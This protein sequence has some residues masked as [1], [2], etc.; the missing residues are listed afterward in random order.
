MKVKAQVPAGDYARFSRSRTLTKNTHVNAIPHERLDHQLHTKETAYGNLRW[1]RS[2]IIYVFFSKM[3]KSTTQK[4]KKK[5]AKSK[6]ESKLGW[7]SSYQTCIVWS[8][9]LITLLLDYDILFHQRQNKRSEPI[10][11]KSQ[12]TWVKVGDRGLELLSK[13]PGVNTENSCGWGISKTPLNHAR[14]PGPDT[15]TGL[16]ESPRSVN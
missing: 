2:A 7:S 9:N 10:I 5:N 13:V 8:A 4:K 11:C 1:A 6:E 15:L 12:K 3:Q 14:L 16:E